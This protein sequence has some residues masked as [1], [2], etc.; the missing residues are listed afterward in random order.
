M[1]YALSNL[2]YFNAVALCISP[3]TL[4]QS[5]GP[6]TRPGTVMIEGKRKPLWLVW[7]SRHLTA[8]NTLQV[9]QRHR[10]RA[11]CAH[12][13]I[14]LTNRDIAGPQGAARSARK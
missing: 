8:L 14:Y 4:L 5:Q 10:Y 9:V 13:T 11:V 12:R 6:G 2:E 1:A 7:R 3:C